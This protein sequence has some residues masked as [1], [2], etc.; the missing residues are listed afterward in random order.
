MWIKG[1]DNL[2]IRDGKHCAEYDPEGIV[3]WI[4]EIAGYSLK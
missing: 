1:K 4:G 3:D 2:S